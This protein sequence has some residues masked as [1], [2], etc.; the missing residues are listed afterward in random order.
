MVAMSKTERALL[1]LER[2]TS[3]Q[4]QPSHADL[5]RDLD[6]Q[7]STLSDVLAE[8]RALRLVELQG[9]QYFPGLRLIRLAHQASRAGLSDSVR[10]AL[11]RLSEATGETAVWVVD[12]LGSEEVV[13]V[14]QVQSAQSIRFVADIGLPW[15]IRATAAGQAFLAFSGRAT[16]DGMEERLTEI[17]RAGYAIVGGEGGGTAIA[18]PVTDARTGFILGAVSVVGPSDRL[19]DPV[20]QVW[21]ALEKETRLLAGAAAE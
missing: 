19:T 8:L 18:A 6:M 9:R 15:P 17:R 5:V 16:P 11:E 13:A 10:A 3:G 7:R 21:P 12:R 14:A 2:V 20:R 1:V 4:P